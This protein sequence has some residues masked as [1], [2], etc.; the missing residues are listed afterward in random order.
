MKETLVL[1][2]VPL[3]YIINL[4]ENISTDIKVKEHPRRVRM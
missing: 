3:R 1:D 4:H 2:F